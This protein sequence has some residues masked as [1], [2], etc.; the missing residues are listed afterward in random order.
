MNNHIIIIL[1]QFEKPEPSFIEDK[2][3]MLPCKCSNS[4]YHIDCIVKFLQSGQ[5][6]NFCPH[7]KTKYN[8][9]LE[10]QQIQQIQQIQEQEQQNQSLQMTNFTHI[11][12]IHILSNSL[13]NVVNIIVSRICAEY[14]GWAEL[15]VLILFYFGK[16]LLNYCILVYSKNNISKIEDCLFYS[17][18]FQT[19]IFGYLIYT[20]TKIKNDG[21][22]AILIL[23]NVLLSLL[24]LTCRIIIEC[25]MQ[26]RVNI[27]G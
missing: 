20:L 13:M 16:L 7:C 11:L 26:N 14:N 2:D 3:V 23:N 18:T 12:V 25:K 4:V 15:Q 9:L 17:Y 24:D 1:Q 5:H 19:I 27:Q 21:N 6:K 10:Q 22:S 8:I